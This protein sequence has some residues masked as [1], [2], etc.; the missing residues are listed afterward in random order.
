MNLIMDEVHVKY[1]LKNSRYLVT[2]LC[3]LHKDVIQRK[4]ELNY[5]RFF[6]IATC[7]YFNLAKDM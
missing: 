5:F 6:K 7:E 2:L 4:P 3:K 1:R